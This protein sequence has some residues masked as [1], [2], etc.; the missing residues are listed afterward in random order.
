MLASRVRCSRP[1]VGRP[2]TQSVSVFVRSAAVAWIPGGI[3]TRTELVSLDTF[4]P[5]ATQSMVQASTE[6]AVDVDFLDKSAVQNN[7]ANITVLTLKGQMVEKIEADCNTTTVRQL[8]QSIAD[9]IGETSVDRMKLVYNAKYLTNENLTLAQARVKP[10]AAVQMYL[11]SRFLGGGGGSAEQEIMRQLRRMEKAELPNVELI[12]PESVFKWNL[13]LRGP[14]ESPY[15]EGL[16]SVTL[17]FPHCYPQGPPAL[18]FN[19]PIFHPNVY[20]DGRVCWYCQDCNG[21]AYQ[22]EV[23]IAALLILFVEPNPG[24]PANGEAAQMYVHDKTK[25]INKAK[26]ATAKLAWN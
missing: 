6:E 16:F 12:T 7:V 25:Y 3:R 4:S 19:T 24:S 23:V 1:A 10:G 8:K 17:L 5:C 18:K 2:R 9:R 22:A 21:D 15:A 11:V 14:A 20:T 26:K 13:L